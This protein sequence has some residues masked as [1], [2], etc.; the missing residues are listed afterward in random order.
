MLERTG[1]YAESWNVAW[2][3]KRTGSIL[4]D[5]DTPFQIIEN[6]FQYW[7]AD[8]FLFEWEEEVYIFAELYDYRECRGGLGY[9]KWDGKKFTRWKKVISEKYHLS[10]PFIYEENGQIY[11]M[12]E[13]G[14]NHELYLYRA[15]QFPDSW[16]KEKVLRK[17]VNYGD[18]SPFTLN[19]QKLAFTYDVSNCEDYQLILLNLQE[20]ALDQKL[21][22]LDSQ[23]LRRPAG[24]CFL[25]GEKMVRPAQNCEHDYGEGLIFY[26]CIFDNEKYIEELI[27]KIDPMQLKYS[28]RMLLDGMHTYNSTDKFE[29]IDLKTRRFNLL[30]FANRILYKLRK[31]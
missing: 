11:I 27:E 4:H 7:V 21:T 8:P 28:K 16:V 5:K 22:Y 29:V 9:A 23:E 12:P 13:S 3:K 20:H 6:S 26:E 24:K 17:N 1:F 25:D 15:V 14:A 10:Y 18:T 19:D 30:N 31:R 2:R